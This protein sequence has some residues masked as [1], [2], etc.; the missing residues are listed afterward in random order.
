MAAARDARR[1]L[2]FPGADLRSGA[3][4]GQLMLAVLTVRRIA[5]RVATGEWMKG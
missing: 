2:P 4:A 3:Q 1:P 5:P